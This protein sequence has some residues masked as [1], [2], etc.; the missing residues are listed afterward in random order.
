MSSKLNMHWLHLF[1]TLIKWI[2]WPRK[3]CFKCFRNFLKHI[4]LRPFRR[5]ILVLNL[6]YTI[7][8]PA[9]SQQSGS[10]SLLQLDMW[11]GH[12]RPLF[13]PFARSPSIAKTEAKQISTRGESNNFPMPLLDLPQL[14]CALCFIWATFCLFACGPVKFT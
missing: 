11:P 8:S 10:Y 9:Q 5:V 4:S 1:Y 2:K 12:I 7:I 6:L 14:I 3:Y 13:R